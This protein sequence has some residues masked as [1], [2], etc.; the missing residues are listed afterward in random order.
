MTPRGT[1]CL[2]CLDKND[3]SVLLKSTII[4]A[5]KMV[6]WLSS[7]RA[8]GS[9]LRCQ[10]IMPRAAMDA[11]GNRWID[12][13]SPTRFARAHKVTPN[14]EPVLGTTKHSRSTSEKPLDQCE[15]KSE[16]APETDICL[17]PTGCSW[18]DPYSNIYVP[19]QPRSGNRIHR[20]CD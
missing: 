14:W 20:N 17:R 11:W 2:S 1:S 10:A 9:K 7:V 3:R 19:F 6:V 13:L 12:D 16:K 4:S 15:V 5:S 18:N 8:S